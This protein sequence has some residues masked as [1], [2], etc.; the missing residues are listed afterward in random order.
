MALTLNG[1]SRWDNESGGEVSKLAGPNE[2]R[3]PAQDRQRTVPSRREILLLCFDGAKIDL[4]RAI[5]PPSTRGQR[6]TRRGQIRLLIVEPTLEEP[7]PLRETRNE[8]FALGLDKGP[9]DGFLDVAR[10]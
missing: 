2:L 5:S 9:A 3:L 10:H 6:T 8:G 7:L 1:I 4:G